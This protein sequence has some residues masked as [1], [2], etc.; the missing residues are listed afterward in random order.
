MEYKWNDGGNVHEYLMVADE[1]E[2]AK[3]FLVMPSDIP[4]VDGCQLKNMK[5]ILNTRKAYSFFT[6]RM[7]K[8]WNKLLRGVCP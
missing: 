3:L 7:V 4:R 5:C 6:V 1:D 8:H 2:G